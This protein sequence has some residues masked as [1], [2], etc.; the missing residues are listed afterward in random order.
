MRLLLLFLLASTT[1][2]GQTPQF[3]DMTDV[4]GANNAT[5]N[6]GVIIGD[7]DNDG[8][9]DL[10]VPSRLDNNRLF[11]NM[12]DGSFEDVT[13][14]ASIEVDGLTMTGAWGDIDN[15][16]DLDLF[17]GNYYT[18]SA[19]FSNYLYR[20]DGNGVFTDISDNAGVATNDQT[21]SVHMLDV[22][23][24][25]SLD[26]YVC[27]LLQQNT[28]WHNNGDNT[29]SNHTF[30]SGLVDASISM[31]A[32]FFDYDN[33]GDQD[34]YLT[35]DGNRQYIMYENNGQGYFT[36]V[37]AETGL[38]VAGQ[39]M[40]VDHGDINNDGHLDIYVTNLGSNFLLLNDGN[41]VYS[42]V[43][44]AANAEDVLGMGWGCFFVD[45][46]NDGWEDIYVVND[47]YFSPTSNKL[48]KNDGDGTF[49]EVS[50]NSPVYSFFDGRAGTWADLNN[51]GSLELIVANGQY[52]VGIQVFE[53]QH[54]ENNWIGFELEGTTVARDAFGTRIQVNTVNGVKIDEKTGGSSYASQSSHRVYFGLGQGEVSDILITWPDGTADFFDELAINQIHSIQQGMSPADQDGDGF[55]YGE[56]CDDNN[57]SVNP[58]VEEIPYNGLDD[59]CDPM[60]PD[61][62][63]DG[64][65]FVLADDC[66]DSNSAINPDAGETPYN[67]IDDDCDPMT[68]DNDLDGDGFLLADDCNDNNSA[69]NPDADEIP[70]N[71]LND[72]CDPMTPDDD[73]DGD[74]YRLAEDCDDNNSAINPDVDEIP[75]NNMDDDCDP[76]TPDDDLDGDGFLLEDDCDDNNSAVNPDAGET[77]YNGTDD[78]CDPMTP[79]D[80]LD[81]DGFLLEDDCDDNNPAINPDAEE[82]PNN[83]IDEDCEEGDLVTSTLSLSNSTVQIFPNPATDYINIV[84]D[85]E[86]DYSIRLFTLNGQVLVSTSNASTVDL[87]QLPAGTYLLE[88]TEPSSNIRV[89][90]KIVVQD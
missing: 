1:L 40:G 74:G 16:G 32:I 7:F 75:Y 68:P 50:T 25:G 38:D 27:N 72:D 10:F 66:D 65:G 54:T 43:A 15:D 64:D 45:Y 35:H 55:E 33:D 79:D 47:S 18:L 87:R 58:D 89:T 34:I 44:A 62:D 83:G 82:I 21:R 46:D 88:I 11:K 23:L 24:D 36:D 31:G 41:G 42:E 56:D 20:N 81:G 49:T 3:V 78:D 71:G 70:Y 37:S 6:N 52:N 8:F 86:V 48:Y 61:D 77:P 63:L 90:E 73:L 69:V 76:M 84:V 22:D 59:D 30:I 5:N 19:P 13:D 67:D 12:G 53:N 85:R 39:G 60:T 9:E 2:W 26:I 17:I 51:D 28:L 57:S 29:F 80:D 14:T 4:A